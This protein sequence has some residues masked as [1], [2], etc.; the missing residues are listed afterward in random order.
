MLQ[1]AIA[2]NH[3]CTQLYVVDILCIATLLYII[4]YRHLISFHN[5]YII[6]YPSREAYCFMA[7]NEYY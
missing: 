1:K 2:I 7:I 4:K 5:E 3:K 6:Y